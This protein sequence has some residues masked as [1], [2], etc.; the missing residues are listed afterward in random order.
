MRL[1]GGLFEHRPGVDRQAEKDVGFQQIIGAERNEEGLR[2]LSL[3]RRTDDLPE[4]PLALLR[5][6]GYVS[7]SRP[8]PPDR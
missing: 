2:L 6:N 4:Q 5:V 1:R 8:R 3:I 7:P